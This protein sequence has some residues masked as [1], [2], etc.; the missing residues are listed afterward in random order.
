MH[1][2]FAL[3]F[4]MSTVMTQFLKSYGLNLY[5]TSSQTS[6][7]AEWDRQNKTLFG[8]EHIKVVYDRNKHYTMTIKKC[9]EEPTKRCSPTSSSNNETF[10]ELTSLKNVSRG[11]VV[12]K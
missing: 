11:A 1:N 8:E 10:T 2:Y 7:T 6:S 12:M 9:V 4:I 3:Y 5:D